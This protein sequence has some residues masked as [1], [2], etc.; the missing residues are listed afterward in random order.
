VPH[1]AAMKQTTGEAQYTDDIPHLNNELIG[2]L[3]LSTKARAKLLK[4]DPSPALEM[5]GV[6]SFVSHLDLPSPEAN[7]W[8]ALVCDEVFFAVDEVFTAGQ[9]IGIILAETELQA[10]AAARAV[11]VEYEDLPAI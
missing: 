11:V 10:A 2:C 9:P 4:V 1:V 6:H 3:V 7:C 8:G 5:P